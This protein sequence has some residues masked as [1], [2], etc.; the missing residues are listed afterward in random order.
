[1]PEL[2]DRRNG[3]D[4]DPPRSRGSTYFFVECPARTSP[5]CLGNRWT[6]TTTGRYQPEKRDATRSRVCEHCHKMKQGRNFSLP[7]KTIP[8]RPQ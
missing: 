7:P 4:L 2:G 6:V 3:K 8:S 1:M 5:R